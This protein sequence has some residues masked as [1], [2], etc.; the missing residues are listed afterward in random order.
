MRDRV[1]RPAEHRLQLPLLD[2]F[3][4]AKSE[5][6][7]TASVPAAWCLT[8]TEEVLARAVLD[9][10]GVVPPRPGADLRRRQHGGTVRIPDAHGCAFCGALAVEVQCGSNRWWYGGNSGQP[11]V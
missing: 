3:T 11:R 5:W 6:F 1:Q 4:D 10:V 7:E 9:L 8:E 2:H